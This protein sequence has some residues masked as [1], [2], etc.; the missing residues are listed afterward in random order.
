MYATLRRLAGERREAW[1][2]ARADLLFRL[3]D[4]KQDVSIL[5]LGG[6][7]GAFMMRVRD[8]INARIT[9]ADISTDALAVAEARG[10]AT[11]TLEELSL[12]HISEPTRPY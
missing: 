1:H 5:D 12:I 4:L 6:Q 9:I 2:S 7:D 10:F 3:L 11:L 8:R